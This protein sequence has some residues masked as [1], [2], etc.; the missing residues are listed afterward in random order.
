MNQPTH[1]TIQGLAALAAAL[2]KPP[3]ARLLEAGWLTVA[4][5]RADAPKTS[6]PHSQL[7]ALTGIPIVTRYDMHPAGWR[8]LDGGGRVLHEHVPDEVE[9]VDGSGRTD[10]DRAEDLSHVPPKE[11]TP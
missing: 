5:L 1:P 2:P 9:P 7:A 3:P 8:I 10:A 4:R 11:S 6:G